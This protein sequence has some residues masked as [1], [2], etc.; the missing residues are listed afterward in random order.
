MPISSDPHF[1]YGYLSWAMGQLGPSLEP[2]VLSDCFGVEE[3]AAIEWW[4]EFTGWYDGVLDES[5]GEVDRP[6]LV[7]VALDGGEC[8]VVE[9]HPGDVYVYRRR[10]SEEAQDTLANF[11]PHWFIPDWSLAGLERLVRNNVQLKK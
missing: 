4:N 7:E 9:A 10:P 8:L 1:W 11:G 5:G 3:S 6:G 2:K